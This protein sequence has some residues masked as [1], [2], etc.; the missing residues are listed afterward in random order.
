MA[1]RTEAQ[2]RALRT[3]VAAALDETVA[4]G[5]GRRDAAT[6][7]ADSRKAWKGNRHAYADG[8]RAHRDRKGGGR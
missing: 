6:G 1:R 8:V 4:L 2:E 7:R 5:Q 3:R